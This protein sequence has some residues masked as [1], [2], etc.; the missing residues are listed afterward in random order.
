MGESLLKTA[1][2]VDR[3]VARFV[4]DRY[5]DI[6]LFAESP[7]LRDE[8]ILPADKQAF[9]ES[10]V[11]TYAWYNALYFV[12]T[13]GTIVAAS[14][15]TVG[16]VSTYDWFQK[17]LEGE[18]VLTD[19]Y[20]LF[21]ARGIVMTLA[22]PVIDPNGQQIGVIASQLDMSTLWDFVNRAR[23]IG[24]SGFT[25]LVDQHERLI[26][27]PDPAVIFEEARRFMP[28]VTLQGKDGFVEDSTV[29]GAS[30]FYGFTPAHNLEDSLG[31]S[32]TMITAV[33]TEEVF[34]SIRQLGLQIAVTAIIL[35]A[36]VGVVTLLVARGI[37]RPVLQLAS[38]ARAIRAGDLSQQVQVSS[39]D[40]LGILA[41]TFNQM[42]DNLRERIQAEREATAYLEQTVDGYL[43]FVERVAAG[44]LAARLSLN[45]DNDAL[46]IL[47]RNLNS[48]VERLGQMTA[49]MRE[50]TANI[51]SAA[52]EILA[53]ATQQVSGA[54]EQSAAISQTTT[55]VDEVKAIAEQSAARAREV[56][57][58]AQRTMQVSQSGQQAV[59]ET[60]ASM[61]Q[62]KARVEGIAENILSL[63]EQTQQ[64]GEIITT[65]NDIASQSNMLALNA[66]V[67]AARAGEQGKGFAVV[68]QEV[69]N[70][71][72]QS[73]QATAQ[74][75]AILSDIQQATNATVMAT[76]EGTKGVDEGARLAAQA[77]EAIAQLSGAIGESAQ[78]AMQMVA[79]GQQQASGV[80]QIALAMENINQVTVQG[81][82]STRQTERSAQGLNE[83]AQGLSEVVEQYQL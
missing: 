19:V 30:R 58:A 36:F 54:G 69:R 42:A 2:T 29:D 71:A 41:T 26:S 66:A 40:E 73:R 18:V 70:L 64:I 82:A 34:G 61:A 12:D 83:L 72:E 39:R 27:H 13:E 38:A 14:D 1:R 31:I 43:V 3:G 5:S 68:A 56:A 21:A 62:I 60:I 55:T 53:A 57:D 28:A 48:M 77:R 16:E 17:A 79:G 15:G 63:S 50:A 4:G 75:R 78:A 76:E 8:S 74:V 44:D 22:A 51:T 24:E 67:E 32:W 9:L 65:V 10:V 45:G 37:S 80:D 47:G 7:I 49:Q 81:L 52:T 23:P 11:S 25:V 35:A 46:T 33:P 20:Y 59:Q 6:Q